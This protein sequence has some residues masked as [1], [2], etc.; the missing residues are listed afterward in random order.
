MSDDAPRFSPWVG[1]AYRHL[2]QHADVLNFEFAGLY[3]DN[4]WNLVGERTLHLAADQGVLLSEWAR[5]LPC[6]WPATIGH[7]ALTRQVHRL[8]IHLKRVLDVRDPEFIQRCG[9]DP[10]ANWIADL[11]SARHFAKVVRNTTTAQAIIVPSI[12]FIDD[13]TRWNLVIFLDK[14]PADISEWVVSTESIGYLRWD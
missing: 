7:R 11:S 14:V 4:R 2:P 8:H 9:V 12:A 13:H 10:S 1:S 3:G 5:S 6:P